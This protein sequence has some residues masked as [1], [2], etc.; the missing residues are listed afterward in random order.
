MQSKAIVKLHDASENDHTQTVSPDLVKNRTFE[1]ATT[2]FVFTMHNR[3]PLSF[4]LDGMIQ[5]SGE[6]EI[7]SRELHSS[8]ETTESRLTIRGYKKSIG[9]YGVGYTLSFRILRDEVETTGYRLHIMLW[10]GNMR[11]SY[12]GWYISDST[13]EALTPKQWWSKAERKSIINTM[14]T[15][16]TDENL[17]KG[18][19]KTLL[20]NFKELKLEIEMLTDN[21]NNSM[22][23][24]IIRHKE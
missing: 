14:K 11:D 20:A 21:E 16:A 13:N 24:M 17:N 4:I 3:S 8:T 2:R 23:S 15:N 10:I 9:L 22:P 18:G 5:D 1:K 7:L 19:G 12:F 6:I